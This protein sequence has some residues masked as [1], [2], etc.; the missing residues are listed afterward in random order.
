M[1]LS[2]AFLWAFYGPLCGGFLWASLSGFLLPIG[3]SMGLSVGAFYGPLWGFLLSMC[4]SVGAFYGPFCGGFLWASETPIESPHRKAHRLGLSAFFRP[5]CEAFFVPCFFL[6]YYSSA[7]VGECDALDAAC[8]LWTGT[9]NDPPKR[10]RRLQK[11]ETVVLDCS[12]VVRTLSSHPF[13]LMG[14]FRVAFCLCF[15]ASPSAK[16]FIWK[17]VLFPC[18]FWFIYM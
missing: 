16:P 7:D 17:L 1:R 6:T 9:E 2:A 8:K 14:D 10:K 4:L 11:K 15:K 12:P 13:N 3:L 5:L 18:K